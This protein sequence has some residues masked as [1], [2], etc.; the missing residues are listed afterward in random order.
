MIPLSNIRKKDRKIIDLATSVWIA[1]RLLKLLVFA[2]DQCISLEI[3]SGNIIIEPEKHNVIVLDWTKAKIHQ[4]NIS[5]EIC[6]N[7]I[8][9][10]ALTIL[11]A[12]GE[13]INKS[14]RYHGNVY[15]DFLK[16]LITDHRNDINQVYKDFETTHGLL[17][18]K[19]FFYPFTTFPL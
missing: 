6:M 10:V 1:G 19:G 17:F 5:D 9:S 13:D 7:D 8:T 3:D 2:H 14:D 4:N 18:E 16:S 15:V 11:S 12:I